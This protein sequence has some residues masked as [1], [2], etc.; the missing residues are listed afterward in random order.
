MQEVTLNLQKLKSLGDLVD[1]D[2]RKVA[3]RE[4]LTLLFKAPGSEAT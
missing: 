4:L 1:P 2:V 3:Q